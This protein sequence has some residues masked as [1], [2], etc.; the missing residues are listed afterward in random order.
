MK[1]MSMFL[2][3]KLFRFAK[4]Q[5]ET[6]PAEVGFLLFIS[7]FELFHLVIMVVFFKI[8]GYELELPSYF[9][10]YFGWI[11]VVLSLLLNYFVFIKSK[12]IYEINNFY[13]SH[14]RQIW[15]DNLLFFGYILFL[16]LL[17]IIETFY[18]K[19]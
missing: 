17:M 5:E 1:N 4:S 16:F 11:F 14:D 19:K 15:K 12:L 13:K 3:Y 2:F 7:I 10:K 9:V 6:V 18:F 8:L